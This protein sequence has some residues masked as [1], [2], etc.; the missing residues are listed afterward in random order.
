[1]KNANLMGLGAFALTFCLFFASQVQSRVIDSQNINSYT[2]D[3]GNQNIVELAES[4]PDLSTFVLALNAAALTTALEDTGPFTVFAPSNA[5][6]AAL[7]PNTFKELM[8]KENKSRLAAILKNHVV[9]GSLRT[10]NLNTGN[11]SSLGGKPLHIEVR[12]SQI[13][14]D[15]ANIVQSD[16]VGSNGII[17]II[18]TVLLV[19]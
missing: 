7:P 14:V 4:T 1:M 6:F 2:T 8:K 10:S 17:Q 3:L 16:L 13:S 12:G 18:D 5:A 19:K 11:L 15:E 9:K